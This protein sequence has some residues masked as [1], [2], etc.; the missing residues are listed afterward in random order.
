MKKF[1][2][3]KSKYFDKIN[4]K[5]KHTLFNDMEN[6]IIKESNEPLI[7]AFCCLIYSDFIF[8]NDSKKDEF[9]KTLKYK[10][11]IDFE[12][13]NIYEIFN[14]KQYKFKKNYILDNLINNNIINDNNV[15][16][17]LGDYFNVNF[18]IIGKYIEYKN[19][20]IKDR[21]NLIVFN[22]ND[23]YLVQR[24]SPELSIIKDISNSK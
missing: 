20:F 2:I 24:N 1:I 15:Y 5:F 11:A 17:Y 7:I 16:R 14:Y 21:Y 8:I 10:M 23:K 19:K 6:F 3:Q 12:K 22:D 13:K 9:I 18:I 4:T